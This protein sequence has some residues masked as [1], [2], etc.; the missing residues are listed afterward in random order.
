M[1]LDVNLD[2]L[3]IS[4]NKMGA[5]P[6]SMDLGVVWDDADVEFDTVI[7][8]SSG[9]EIG[10]QDVNSEQGL[11]SVK[12]RQV[13]LFIPDH[14]FKVE[15]AIAD[16][17]VGKKF[18]IAH[19]RTLEEM[20]RR[21]RFERYKVT[22]NLSGVFEVYGYNDTRQE[23]TGEARLA[24]CKN[25]LNLLNYKG[26]ANG[27]AANRNDIVNTFDIGEFFST[28]S[29]LFKHLPKGVNQNVKGYTTDWREVSAKVRQSAKYVC[30][31]CH[32]D[33]SSQKNLLHVHH[34]NGV[35][36]DNSEINLIVLCA[37][38]HRKEPMHEHL[39]VKHSDTQTINRLRREQNIIQ[40]GQPEWDSVQELADPSV[41]GILDH[42]QRKGYS[43]PEVGYELTTAKGR[44]I[45]ELE[46][47][48]PHKKFGIFIDEP[49]ENSG[50]QLLSL[51]DALV[52]FSTRNR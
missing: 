48:W 36:H 18:H 32:V 14:G 12:G 2:A 46:L 5:E 10:I 25:C 20:K 51:K 16:G 9:F 31:N 44:V 4:V 45:A 24:V 7:S 47:A 52:L 33:L 3:W 22:N 13:L 42:A 30:Q 1:K 41:H 35:K 40:N 23:I 15:D 50:W 11:L 39:F 6:V 43:P 49:S 8:S 27:T 19:C 28:Y 17:A 34:K 21:N 38:C 37:D 29:S 26:A